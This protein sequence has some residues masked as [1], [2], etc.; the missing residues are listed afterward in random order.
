[1]AGDADGDSCSGKFQSCAIRGS[2]DTAPSYPTPQ[3]GLVSMPSTAAPALPDAKVRCSVPCL[4]TRVVP[5]CVCLC[6]DVYLKVLDCVRC[7]FTEG[8]IC[9]E[10]FLF[11]PVVH[12][13]HRLSLSCSLCYR[14]AC[15][16]SCF[17]FCGLTFC[18]SCCLF[19]RQICSISCC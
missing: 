3:H 19:C 14:S 15:Y 11:L 13:S 10:L 18:I 16:I 4:R 12:A 9:M 1:M 2:D 8:V 6:E 5:A 7:V 17:P